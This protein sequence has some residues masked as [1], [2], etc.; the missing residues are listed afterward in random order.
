MTPL[1][2]VNAKFHK[3]ERLVNTMVAGTGYA[4]KLS[5]YIIFLILVTTIV[6]IVYGPYQSG[7]NNQKQR[8]S[9]AVRRH[10]RRRY[11]LH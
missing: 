2:P 9:S 3:L 4:S 8:H 5:D 6:A 7:R 11:F 10:G 1:G